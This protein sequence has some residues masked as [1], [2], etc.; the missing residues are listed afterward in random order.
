MWNFINRQRYQT[1]KI[2]TQEDIKS[3]EDTERFMVVL[4]AEC[5]LVAIQE[6]WQTIPQQMPNAIHIDDPYYFFGMQNLDDATKLS[7]SLRICRR[8]IHLK[9][10]PILQH[11]FLKAKAVLQDVFIIQKGI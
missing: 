1:S 10:K 5:L 8:V 4:S 2:G 3:S 9:V 7:L 6:N 11:S